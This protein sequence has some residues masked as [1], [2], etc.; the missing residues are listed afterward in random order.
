MRTFIALILALAASVGTVAGINVY[1]S[2]E[3]GG[4]VS[5]DSEVALYGLAQLVSEM[6]MPQPLH[7][8]VAGIAFLLP[9]IIVFYVVKV[10]FG[11]TD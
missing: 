2:Q 4:P 10:L 3:V 6:G 11:G 9:P 5:F 7:F 1:L 8:V